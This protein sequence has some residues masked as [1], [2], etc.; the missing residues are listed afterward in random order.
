[1]GARL[2][3]HVCGRAGGVRVAAWLDPWLARHLWAFILL[4]LALLGAELYRQT[5]GP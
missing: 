4:A 5:K 3:C 1:M 2:A